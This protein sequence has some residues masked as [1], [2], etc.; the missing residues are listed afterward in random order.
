MKS[1]AVLIVALIPF[2]SLWWGI[3]QLIVRGCREFA[4]QGEGKKKL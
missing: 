4:I 3:L 1:A 2:L